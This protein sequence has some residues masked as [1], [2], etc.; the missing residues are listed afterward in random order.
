LA[1]GVTVPRSILR[2]RF[3]RSSGPGGQNVNKLNTRVQLMVALSDLAPY[4]DEAAL[5][6][7]RKMAGRLL[8]ERDE[9]V[10][11]SQVSRSQVLNRQACVERL[12]QMVLQARRRPRRRIATK[13]T[14]GAVRRRLE[15]KKRRSQLK[16]NRSG[17]GD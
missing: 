15:A 10:L 6:R 3:S 16:R 11:S 4:L 9:L 17:W 13:P 14:A 1:P 12:G 2:F 5:G 7:L 8:S